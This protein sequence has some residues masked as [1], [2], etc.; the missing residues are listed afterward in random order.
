[1]SEGEAMNRNIIGRFLVGAMTFTIALPV[2]ADTE[3]VDGI[4]WNYTVVDGKAHIYNSGSAAIS[5]TTTGAITIPSTLGGCPVTS[6][7]SRAFYGCGS[8]TSVTI[9]DGVTSYGESAFRDCVGLT[10]VVMKAGLFFYSRTFQGCISLRHFEFPDG[11]THVGMCMFLG[12]TNLVSVKLSPGIRT[13]EAG[14]FYGCSSLESIDACNIEY[15][16]DEAFHDCSSLKSLIIPVDVGTCA[17]EGCKALTE[18]SIPE[19]TKLVRANTFA[20]C[21]GLTNIIIPESVTNIGCSAF[22]RCSSLTNIVIGGKVAY[23][24][25][26]AFS[27]LASLRTVEFL[28]APPGAQYIVRVVSG[29]SESTSVKTISITAATSGGEMAGDVYAGYSRF[30]FWNCPNAIGYYRPKFAEAWTAAVA[31]YGDW[32]YLPMQMKNEYITIEFDPNGGVVSPTSKQVCA[33]IAVGEL[34]VAIRNG[35]TFLGWYKDEG[36]SIDAYSK[37]EKDTVVYAV[38]QKNSDDGS[39]DGGSN[40]ADTADGGY[41]E[42]AAEAG[43]GGNSGNGDSGGGSSGGGGFIGGGSGSAVGETIVIRNEEDFYG[44]TTNRTMGKTF[45]LANDLTLTGKHIV[46]YSGG[47]VDTGYHYPV[48]FYGALKGNGHTVRLA[49]SCTW[50]AVFGDLSGATIENITFVLT[51]QAAVSEYGAERTTFS[52]VLV[53]VGALTGGDLTNC[54]LAHCEVN[55]AGNRDNSYR[56]YVYGC[57]G[58]KADGCRFVDC[59]GTGVFPRASDSAVGFYWISV[60]GFVR[61]AV[62]TIFDGCRFE[63]TVESNNGAGGLAAKMTKCFVKNCEVNATVAG[64]LADGQNA[65]GWNVGGIAGTL[66]S[67]T[68]QVCRVVGSVSQLR[69]PEENVG[70]IAGFAEEKSLISICFSSADIVGRENVGGIVGYLRESDI[71]NVESLGTVKGYWNVGGIVGQSVGYA[72]RRANIVCAVASGAVIG[73]AADSLEECCRL[74]GFAG[75]LVWSDVSW[76]GATGRVNCTGKSLSLGGFV[77]KIGECTRISTS[78]ATG[79]VVGDR[80]VGGFSGAVYAPSE[81]GYATIQIRNCYARGSATETTKTDSCGVAAF[82]AD[83]GSSGGTILVE[84]CYAT[85]KVTASAPDYDP[86]SFTVNTDALAQ[87]GGLS[88]ILGEILGVTI[89]ITGSATSSYWDK[90]TTGQ[91]QSGLMGAGKTTAE[92]GRQ[93]TYVGWDFNTIWIMKNGYPALRTCPDCEVNSAELGG[94]SGGSGDAAPTIPISTST[95]EEEQELFASVIGEIPS[96]AASEYN[97]YLV[98]ANG[99]VKGTIQVKVGKPGKKDGKAAVKAAVV[100]G[101]KKVSL[102]AEDKGKVKIAADGPTEVVLVGGE[103]CEVTL[104][105]QGVSGKYGVYNIDGVRNFFASKDKGEQSAANTILGKWLGSVNVVWG[106]GSLNVSIAK[107]GKAKVKGTIANG[108]KVS[109]NA[110]FLVGEEWCAVPVLA[111][112]AN[113]VFTLWL[114]CDGHTAIV[115]G[116]GDNV[117]VGK[118]GTLP[119]GAAFQIVDHNKFL[120]VLGQDILPYLPDGVAVKQSGTKWTLPKAGKVAYK[121]GAVDETKLGENPCGLKLTYKA[122]DGSFKG[123]FKV[124]AEVNGKPKATTVSV[125][126]FMLNGV[127]YGTATIK[128][129]GLTDV[130]VK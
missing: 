116:L 57:F 118:V 8:L 69:H 73:L 127:G 47:P 40:E 34:P 13:I 89:G 9:P 60:G 79:S 114:S 3:I 82:T 61:E 29:T 20:G 81:Y 48:A 58:G 6:I 101:A 86:F 41:S 63:G 108:T 119:D 77:G 95:S 93:S 5:T 52:N 51:P 17:F 25:E 102:K 105:D 76:C 15:I 22:E 1:M 98:D 71:E 100:L 31:S 7:G 4:E 49:S 80:L 90:Q 64:P 130:T 12:C 27:N 120:S 94:W 39:S 23:I 117:L 103:A 92:M 54:T 106:G 84:N 35:Y 111:P 128:G 56:D 109:A 30:V 96:I 78:Y 72:S 115:D 46:Q 24:G 45:I 129:K 126:G 2:W 83:I 42:D 43:G 75:A 91:T 66:S 38:W 37:I 55:Y 11:A 122:K 123:S 125:A 32:Q 18:I 59:K 97:G 50:I 10:D 53:S 26:S 44:I 68:V 113:L 16:G 14:A 104:G 21:I 62:S 87:H 124:Y 33:G 67:S 70:G 99:A 65:S 88:P 112:K 110:T 74:G 36:T 19:G 28:G 121:N 85:G 107:K